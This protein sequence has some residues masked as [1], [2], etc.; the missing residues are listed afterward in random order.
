MIRWMDEWM[1]WMIWDMMTTK[2]KLKL[3]LMDWWTD[4]L[5]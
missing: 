3:K 5:E 1:D 4:G 2:L